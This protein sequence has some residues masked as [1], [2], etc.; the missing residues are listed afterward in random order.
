MKKN[1]KRNRGEVSL[2]NA[3]ELYSIRGKIKKNIQYIFPIKNSVINKN[4]FC[5]TEIHDWMMFLGWRDML[6]KDLQLLVAR[7]TISVTEFTNWLKERRVEIPLPSFHSN[8]AMW[9]GFTSHPLSLP[10]KITYLFYAKYLS[11]R[12]WIVW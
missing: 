1:D 7:G 2:R 11:Q 5:V 12:W 6:C 9:L 3:F 8:D 10:K 4:K